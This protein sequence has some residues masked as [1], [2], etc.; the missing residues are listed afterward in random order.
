MKKVLRNKYKAIGAIAAIILIAS[1]VA[2]LSPFPVGNKTASVYAYAPNWYE[3]S[4][5]SNGLWYQDINNPIYVGGYQVSFM[6]IYSGFAGS[7]TLRVMELSTYPRAYVD[8]SSHVYIV[9]TLFVVTQDDLNGYYNSQYAAEGGYQVRDIPDGTNVYVDSKRMVFLKGET[10]IHYAGEP[11]PGNFPMWIESESLPTPSWVDNKNTVFPMVFQA[12]KGQLVQVVMHEGY[13]RQSDTQ[14]WTKVP[15]AL[16]DTYVA[17]FTG[18]DTN[19]KINKITKNK[20]RTII[21]IL[22]DRI[23]IP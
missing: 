7:P 23:F 13:Y 6:K 5:L 17:A 8:T 18:T 1:L 3:D 20:D 21:R 22:Y 9:D 10:A 12:I 14:T 2:M 15:Q 19:V 4:Q 11:L 16:F